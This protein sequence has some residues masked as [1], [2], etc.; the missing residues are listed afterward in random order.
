MVA[1]A[2]KRELCAIKGIS[3]AKVEKIFAAGNCAL[4]GGWGVEGGSVDAHDVP[5]IPHHLKPQ[6]HP[7]LAHSVQDG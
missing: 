7:H 5:R 1:H 4:G 6:P 2:S 3:E